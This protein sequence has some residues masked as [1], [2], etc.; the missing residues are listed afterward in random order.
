MQGLKPGETSQ[1]V[2]SPFG[3]HLIRV[4]ERRAAGVTQDRR[5]IEARQTIKER[6]ADEAFQDWLR[7]L[8]DRTYVEMLETGE[9]DAERQR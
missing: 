9:P 5:R 7:L 1:P 8:R 2:K 6:K 3:W 4:M